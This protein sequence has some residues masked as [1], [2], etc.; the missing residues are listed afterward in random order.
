[1]T[2]GLREHMTG[3]VGNDRSEGKAQAESTVSDIHELRWS[4]PK[5]LSEEA[6]LLLLL[7]LFYYFER[8][9]LCVAQS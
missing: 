7:L 6:L 2:S 4:S 1:M 8:V 3:W 9:S 5:I